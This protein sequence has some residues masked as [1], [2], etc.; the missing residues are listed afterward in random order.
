MYARAMVTVGMVM[1]L[2]AAGGCSQTQGV[3]TPK[4]ANVEVSIDEFE[5]EN[6]IIKEV[7]VGVGGVL[8]VTLG[9]NPTTGFSWNEDAVVGAASV[10]KQTGQEFVEPGKEGVVGA[11]GKEVWTFNALKKGTTV[12]S[13]EYGRPWEGGEK[14]VWTFELTVTV[15]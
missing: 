7:E 4:D 2:V 3:S 8:T 11:A 15:K 9:S 1:V 6:D 10:L 5:A 13:M 12:V 14:G